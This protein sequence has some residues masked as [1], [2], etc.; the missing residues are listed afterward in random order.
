M[1]GE[2]GCSRWRGDEGELGCEGGQRGL[3]GGECDEKVGV[4]C[5]EA[6]E[7]LGSDVCGI[8]CEVDERG[9]RGWM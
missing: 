2:E 7:G 4:F 5:K 6:D 9:L 3:L 8:C 1:V